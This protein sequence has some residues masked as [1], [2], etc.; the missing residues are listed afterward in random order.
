MFCMF[1]SRSLLV[2]AHRWSQRVHSSGRFVVYHVYGIAGGGIRSTKH[3][4]QLAVH[5]VHMCIIPPLVLVSHV[6]FHVPRVGMRSVTDA[7]KWSNS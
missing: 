5:F 2:I 3:G 6:I 4:A 7:F 1:V